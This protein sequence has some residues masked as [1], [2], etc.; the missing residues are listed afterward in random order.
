MS[1]LKYNSM[2]IRYQA[3]L[4]WCFNFVA[5]KLTFQFG[6]SLTT[7]KDKQINHFQFCYNVYPLKHSGT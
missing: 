4:I 2:L 5:V 3:T 1:Y 7:L 6:L